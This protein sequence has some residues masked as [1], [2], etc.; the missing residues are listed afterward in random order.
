MGVT[1]GYT[2]ALYRDGFI[3]LENLLRNNLFFVGTRDEGRLVNTINF[4]LGNTK[5]PIFLL[6]LFSL[7]SKTPKGAN[8]LVTKIN[9]LQKQNRLVFLLNMALPGNRRM[10]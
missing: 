1:L 5:G 6:A 2:G 9:T 8:S 3:E 10:N 4:A 7:P